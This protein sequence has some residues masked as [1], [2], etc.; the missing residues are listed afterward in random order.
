MDPNRIELASTNLLCNAAFRVRDGSVSSTIAANGNLSNNG[1]A[2]SFT[3]QAI[4]A[5]TAL[6]DWMT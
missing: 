1:N 6:H 2:D 4:V 3:D 5:D